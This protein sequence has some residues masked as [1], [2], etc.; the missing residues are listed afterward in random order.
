[1]AEEVKII[2]VAG[3][4]AAEATLQELLR[5]TKQMAANRG[6]GGGGDAVAAKTTDLYTTAVTRGITAKKGFTK[7]VDAGSGALKSFGSALSSIGGLIT[8]ALGAVIGVASNFANALTNAT[9]IGEVLEAIPI[10]GSLLGKATGYFQ[11]SVNTFRELSEVG[12]G[13]GNDMLAMRSA[14]ANSGLSLDMFAQMVSSNSTTMGLLGSSTSEGAARMGRLTKELRSQTRGLMD[15]GLTQQQLNDGFASYIELQASSGR[16]QGQ[17]DAQLVEGAQAYLLE[18]DQLSRVTGKSRKEL[19]DQMQA[20]AQQANIAAIRFNLEGQALA[21]FDANLAHVTSMLPGMSDAFKDLSDGV[22]QTPLGKAL[23]S[24]VPGLR[25]LAQRNASGAISQEEFQAQLRALTPQIV[26]F[27]RQFGGAGGAVQALMGREGLGELVNLAAQASTYSSRLAE[28]AKAIEEQRRRAPLTSLFANFEQTIQNIRS[29]FENAF[30]DS[31]VLEFIG[32]ELGEGGKNLLEGI[33]GLA[34]TLK[35]YLGSDKFKADFKAFRDGLEQFKQRIQNFLNTVKEKGLT[36]ALK[37]LFKN[38]GGEGGLGKMFGDWVKGILYD[39]L[40]NVSTIIAGA[41]GAIGGV[42]VSLL[43]GVVVGPL[44]APFLAIAGALLAIFGV[45]K[46]SEWFSSAWE[47]LKGVAT[48]ISE[49]FSWEGIKGWFSS[50]WDSITGIPKSIMETFTGDGSLGP[51]LRTAIGAVFFIP[52]KIIELFNLGSA[53]ELFSGAWNAVT[54]IPRRIMEFFNIESATQLF[55][56]AWSK[57]SGVAGKV[58][59]IFNV[60]GASQFFSGAW[61]RVRGVASRVGEVF[62][63]DTASQLFSSAWDR[64]RSVG[65]RLSEV[66]NTDNLSV[67]SISDMFGGVINRVREFFNFELRVPNFR[68]YLPTW[69][70][71]GGKPLS[72]LFGGGAPGGN[73][74]AAP[75]PAQSGSNARQA[76]QASLTVNFTGL[77]FN[78]AVEGANRLNA[79][80]SNLNALQG[81]N[82]EL[83]KVRT[84]L[85][86]LATSNYN[87]TMQRLTESFESLSEVIAREKANI[88]INSFGPSQLQQLTQQRPI[89]GPIGGSNSEDQS[90]KL[91]RLNMTMNMIL[92][93]LNE[94]N[95]YHRRTS[96]AVQGN[97]QLGIG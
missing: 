44:A 39:M 13:F 84:G 95:D 28:N 29:T 89:I 37:E 1:M 87:S 86:I 15:L 22:A 46:V 83:E 54:S 73:Q 11:T 9:T 82:A 31:G 20:N 71:G 34:N 30:I 3:G 69:L 62:N 23:E 64:V 57:V 92:A 25:E 41:L 40:P 45:N 14:A 65:S 38:A 33:Q 66:F 88:D 75:Q 56:G 32:T 51:L 78:A 61:D 18:L 42:L 27:T 55:S 67:P 52:N 21:N 8:S 60:E 47:S 35:E 36:E 48:S 43:L 85:D 90:V 96:K 19:Q 91:D 81:F 12:A 80:L 76:S 50:A 97:L 26:N 70:G 5:V 79:T 72:E 16:L 68:E 49:F 2:D 77:D 4:P 10:F 59:E 93:S 6:G 53:T 74:A 58:G 17:T 24:A 94:A 63:T 7:A